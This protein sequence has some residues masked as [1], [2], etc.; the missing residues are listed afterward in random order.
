RRRYILRFQIFLYFAFNMEHVESVREFCL[1]LPGTEEG[2]PFGEQTLVFKVG[3]KMYALMSLDSGDRINLKC[4]PEYA[5]ELREKHAEEIL[6][7]WHMNK[8]HWNTVIFGL[9]LESKLLRHLIRHSYELV[10]SKLP[11]KVKTE[12]NELFIDH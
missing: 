11:K 2:F 5:I 1:S 9:G 7:G 12:I 10:F 8:K 6:P 3:G 4:D